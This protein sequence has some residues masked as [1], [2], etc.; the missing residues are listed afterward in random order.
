MTKVNPIPTL[1]S[2]LFV[3]CKCRLLQG[4]APL[5][6]SIERL[7]TDNIACMCDF[8]YTQQK[9]SNVTYIGVV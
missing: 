7:N 1:F 2:E 6:K 3:L 4:P 5:S 9:G 8:K